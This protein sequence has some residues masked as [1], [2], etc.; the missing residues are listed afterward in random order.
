MQSAYLHTTLRRE[1]LVESPPDVVAALLR[2]EFEATHQITFDTSDPDNL[3]FEIIGTDERGRPDVCIDGVLMR[4][5]GTDTRVMLQGEVIVPQGVLWQKHA[6]FFG[7]MALLT[8]VLGMASRNLLLLPTSFEQ[9]AFVCGLVTVF[10]Y[11]FLWSGLA[12]R[13]RIFEGYNA[14]RHWVAKQS[15]A[16]LASRVQQVAEQGMTHVVVSRLATTD[17]ELADF[18]PEAHTQQVNAGPAK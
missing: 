15:M 10:G 9:S 4:W 11:L 12:L 7:I 14:Q 13:R 6:A 16:A 5:H 3:A 8:V 17:D 2:H 1:F 18:T